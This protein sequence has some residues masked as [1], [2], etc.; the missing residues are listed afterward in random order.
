[1]ITI[2]YEYTPVITPCQELIV[3]T[4]AFWQAKKSENDRSRLVEF[5]FFD[6]APEQSSVRDF[7]FFNPCLDI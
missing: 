1:M 2:C 3:H 6:P 4:S 7:A 5:L